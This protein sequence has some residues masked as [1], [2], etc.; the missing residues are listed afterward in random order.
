MKAIGGLESIFKLSVIMNMIDNLTGPMAKVHSSVDGSVSKIESLNQKFGS[1]AKGGAII[2][3]VGAQITDAVLAPVEATF[4]T[5]TA[6]GTLSSMGVKD[7]GKLETAAKNFSDTWAGTTK[8]DFLNAAVDIKGGIDSLNDEGV[9]KYTEL[10]GL[11]AKATTAT[12]DEMTSLFATGYGIYKG[13]YSDLSDMQFG[14]M[15]SAGLSEAILVFKA[16]GKSMADSIEALGGAATTANVPMEEQLS[17]LGQLQ[18]TM[19]GSEAGTKYRAFLRTAAQAGKELGLSFV[20][21]NNQLLSMPEILGRLKSKYGETLDAIE[22]QKIQTAFGSDEAVSLIDL[23]YSKTGDLQKNILTMYDAMG[24]GSSLTRQ[25]A[26]EINK[27]DGQKYLALKQQLHN[28]TEEIGKSLLPNANQLMSMGRDGLTR[29]NEWIQGN[30]ELV[31]VIMT[32]LLVLGSVLTVG[33]ST[34][35]VIGGVALVFTKTAGILGGFKTALLKVPGLLTDLHIK[36][37][38][39][40][41]GLNMA[42]GKVRSVASGAATGI[43]NAAGAVGRFAKE[44]AVA[45]AGGAKRFAV[46]LAGMARQAVTTATTALPGLITSVWGFTAALLANPVTWIVIGIVALIAVIILLRQNWEQVSAFLTSVW[47]N[48]VSGVGAGIEN[49]KNGIGA[50]PGWIQGKLAAFGES[51]KK[52]IETFVGGIKSAASQPVEA[53]KSIFGKVRQ[54]LPFSDAKEGPFS[55]LTLN[56]RRI[57]ETVTTGIN[58]TSDLPS[59]AVDKS[60]GKVDFSASKQPIKK[61]SFSSEKKETSETATTTKEKAVIIQKLIFQVGIDKLKELPQLFALIKE[62]EDYINSNGDSGDEDPTPEPA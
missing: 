8:P 27:T 25:M 12:I 42:F 40:G 17:I 2:A 48:V 31:K 35:A 44:T 4:D 9:A 50:I 7:L 33:G 28:V 49:I 5:Q 37:L 45:A 24:Q 21:T 61:V 15:F 41:D 18:A 60:F 36:A 52:V 6:L 14:E 53:V 39:A 43:G 54:L 11:T 16:S 13:Y 29:V 34:I 51:G 19:S 30:Q 32:V 59:D 22:K 10:A 57:M 26:E 3:G 20:D 56:G 58:Q 55:H 1:M 47:N 23:M 46:S 62:L 38:Y